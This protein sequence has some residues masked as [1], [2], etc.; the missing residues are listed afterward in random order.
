MKRLD[1]MILKIEEVGLEKKL[2]WACRKFEANSPIPW[3][4][5]GTQQKSLLPNVSGQSYFIQ[6][7]NS[8]QNWTR[9]PSTNLTILFGKF[10][11]M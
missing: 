8:C 1:E 9:F 3:V 5:L 4:E 11:V 2:Q 10:L 6:P 7:Q